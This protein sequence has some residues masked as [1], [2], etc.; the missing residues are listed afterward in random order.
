[1]IVDRT[2][3]KLGVRRDVVRC[4]V[5]IQLFSWENA[6]ECVGAAGDFGRTERDEKRAVSSH[7]TVSEV[8]LAKCGIPLFRNKLD[9]FCYLH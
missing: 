5:A 1:M 9:D 6:C 7:F 2:S 3:A 4:D 8:V